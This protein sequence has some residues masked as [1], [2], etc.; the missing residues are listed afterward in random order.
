MFLDIACFYGGDVHPGGMSKER[1]LHI[2]IDNNISPI[3]AVMSLVQ[4]ALVTIDIDDEGDE[5]LQLH[6]Q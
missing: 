2:Q 6:D 3:Y 5:I 1:D 4:W